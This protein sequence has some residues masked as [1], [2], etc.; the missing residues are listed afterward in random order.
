MVGPPFF[1]DF[2]LEAKP[3][4]KVA[5]VGPS[6]C[7][8][9]S[10]VALIERFYDPDSGDVLIDGVPL[11][12]LDLHWWRNQVCHAAGVCVRARAHARVVVGV[13]LL[14]SLPP[15]SLTLCLD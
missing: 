2:N 9:S 1:T 3:G 5:L 15:L 12:E 13:W 8:K 6:G 11:R 4:Q 7:G 14:V 10:V